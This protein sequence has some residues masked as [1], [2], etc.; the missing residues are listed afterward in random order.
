[1]EVVEP[2]E[3]DFEIRQI[4]GGLEIECAETASCWFRRV[5][6]WRA[7]PWAVAMIKGC[8]VS[9]CCTI[10]G[11]L[12]LTDVGGPRSRSWEVIYARTR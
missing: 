10:G 9:C 5:L 11:D 8:R 7:G 4:E 2:D 12:R 1:V 3:Q 6:C